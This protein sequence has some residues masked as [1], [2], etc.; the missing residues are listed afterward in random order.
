M[1]RAEAA[2]WALVLAVPAWFIVAAVR[3]IAELAR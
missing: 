3:G 2:G 1:S